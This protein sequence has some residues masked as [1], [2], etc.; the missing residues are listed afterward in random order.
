M[1]IA[2]L[3]TSVVPL[4]FMRFFERPLRTAGSLACWYLALTLP[5]FFAG[6][7]ICSPL[8]RGVRG[9]SWLYGADLIGAGFGAVL[10]VFAVSLLGGAGTVWAAA[11]VSLGG[12]AIFAVPQLRRPPRCAIL[13]AGGLAVVG[14]VTIKTGSSW[15]QLRSAV[16][17]SVLGLCW[18]TRMFISVRASTFAILLN[19]LAKTSKRQALHYSHRMWRVGV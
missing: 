16:E 13:L 10:A 15:I 17:E 9:I 18:L 6:L 14:T 19:R 3:I 8:G 4:D 7:A 5:F 11:I 1:L 12:A 2:Y